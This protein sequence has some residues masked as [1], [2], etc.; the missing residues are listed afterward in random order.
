MMKKKLGFARTFKKAKRF[1][2]QIKENFEGNFV[3]DF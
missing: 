2:K 3:L 1:L